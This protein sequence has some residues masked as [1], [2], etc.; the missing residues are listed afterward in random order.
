MKIKSY[1]AD[2]IFKQLREEAFS[3]A[4]AAIES[5]D[6]P[7]ENER[8]EFD[9]PEELAGIFPHLSDKLVNEITTIAINY[10]QLV[11]DDSIAA[12]KEK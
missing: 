7:Q 12:H 3:H 10:M 1:V 8:I 5:G 4:N 2:H 9:L 11:F 6:F